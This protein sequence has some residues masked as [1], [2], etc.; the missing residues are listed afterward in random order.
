[1]SFRRPSRRGLLFR[2]TLLL[3]MGLSLPARASEDDPAT[4]WKAGVARS[5][6]TPKAPLWL[7]G[8][9]MRDRP[10]EGTIHDLWVKALVLEDSSGQR[11]VVVVSDLLGLTKALYD[12]ISAKVQRR[13]RLD[14]SQLMLTSTHTHSGPV[15]AGSLE[16]CY[17][18]D[19]EQRRRIEE[20]SRWL[21]DQVVE[22]IVRASADRKPARLSRGEGRAT[23]AVNRRNNREPE[24][25][26]LSAE[27]TP[28]KGPVDHSTPVLAVRDLEGNL[29]AT[30]FGYA[31]HNTNLDGYQWCGD[32]A[33]FAQLEVERRHPGAVA[34]FWS[35]CG[36]D[37]NP[38]PRRSLELCRGYGHQLAEAVD[39][40][41]SEPME[42]VAPT[43]K[44]AFELV[45]LDFERS[46]QRKELEDMKVSS[47]FLHRRWAEGI[48]RKLDAGET[49]P[50]DYR[51]PIL[52]WR[53]GDEQIWIALGGEV[54][55]DYA[56]RFKR[57]LGASTWITGYANDV[58]AYIPSRRIQEEGGYEAGAMHVYGLPAPGWA[59]DV[60]ERVASAVEKL[61]R[62]IRSP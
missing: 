34:L 30:V 55:V 53:L 54:V 38:L 58:M 9:A 11:S 13:L 23:F 33:G 47:S 56:L 26:A 51:Y 42:P 22:T 32:Y 44:T 15:L 50:I 3:A 27:G 10:S 43:L 48:L 28:L 14:R 2:W 4:T 29:L 5:V 7:A 31:C 60:E 12:G 39:H 17:P 25:P 18:L 41:L 59:P 57:E 16:P 21:E 62:S 35:G 40:V 45:T 36:A 8:Y 20:Y 52:A 61:V 46:F 6:I 19:D 49:L 37:Q 24:V 1:M